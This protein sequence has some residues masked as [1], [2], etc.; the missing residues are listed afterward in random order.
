MTQAPA[1]GEDERPALER[2]AGSQ[3]ATG[4]APPEVARGESARTPLLVLGSVALT[5]WLAAGVI[6][7]AVVLLWLVV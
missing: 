6:A 1:P 5:V 4:G 3:D 2:R 7:A